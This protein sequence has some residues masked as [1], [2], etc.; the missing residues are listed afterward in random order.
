MST[1]QDVPDLAMAV[2]PTRPDE[3]LR[4]DG[5]KQIALYLSREVRTVQRWARFEDLPVHKH[6]HRMSRT[7]YALKSEIDAWLKSRSELGNG[8]ANRIGN[9]GPAIWTVPI[10]FQ[11]FITLSTHFGYSER[12]TGAHAKNSS[13]ICTLHTLGSSQP[14]QLR[15]PR[16]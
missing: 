5:W 14:K 4:L 15:K 11:P 2:I 10:S 8:N 9:S 13:K 1:L 16:R 6:F 7:V 3:L 12:L